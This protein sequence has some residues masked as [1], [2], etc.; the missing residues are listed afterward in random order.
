MILISILI[1]YVL[2]TKLLRDV[3]DCFDLTITTNEPTRIFTN[4]HGHT[5]FSCIDYMVTNYFRDLVKCEICNLNIA[6]HLAHVIYLNNHT[7]IVESNQQ[8]SVAIYN[9]RSLSENNFNYFNAMLSQI[10]WS[11][12]ETLNTNDYFAFFTDTILWCLDVSCPLRKVTLNISGQRG[13]NSKK[14]WV[15]EN[16]IQQIIYLKQ[17]YW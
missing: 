17:L 1:N 8:R 9:K 15:N 13:I 10:D 16:I 12:M 6:D 3:L 7:E 4:A 14:E 2:D 5:T 11:P